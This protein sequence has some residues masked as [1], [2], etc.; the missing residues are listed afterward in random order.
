MQ[1]S[2][3]QTSSLERRMT[4]GVPK[5]RIQQEIQT[6]LQSL[7]RTAKLNGFRPGKVPF[8]VVQQKYGRQVHLEVLDEVVTNSLQE[9]FE[10][11]KIKPAGRP[12]I[13]FNTDISK[14]NADEDLSFTAEFEVYPELTQLKSEGLNILKP[15]AEVTDADVDNMLQKLREQRR[16][17]IT[18]ERAATEDDR[19][20]IDF[21]GTIDGTVFDNN[22]I[23]DM[24]LELKHADVVLAGLKDGLLGISAGEE[25]NLSLVFP[26][27]H[28]NPE[29][30]GKPVECHITAKA[31]AEAMLPALDEAFA[32][33]LGVETGSLDELRQD[34]RENMGRELSYALKS[35]IKK[36][37]L[38]ALIKANPIELPKSLVENEVEHLISAM[39]QQSQYQNREMDA[40]D[41][42]NPELQ[43]N[44]QRRVHMGLLLSELIKTNEIRPSAEKIR[45]M[46]E[47]IASTYEQ[48]EAVVNYYY[49]DH[50]RL[51]EIEAVVLEES[52]VEWLLGRADVTEE[53]LDFETVMRQ[54]ETQA[55][56]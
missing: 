7:A 3:E 27:H 18:V 1:V 23:N 47:T 28:Q 12:S 40:V 11:E 39:K 44:A 38:D 43:S 45:E 5:E 15:V 30:A 6:R 54:Q 21:V 55:Q 10:Q 13:D 25:R 46:I 16:D 35:K 19:V 2:I 4:V 36:R 31:V 41:K 9:A 14:L 51:A 20:T 33:S 52:V 22:T 32:Q 56:E 29:L 42:T 53:T 48:P 50:R 8:R 49:S 26:E 34:V 37:I 24:P 17:W